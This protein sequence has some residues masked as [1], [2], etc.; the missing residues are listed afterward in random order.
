MCKSEEK[1]ETW[2]DRGG[3]LSKGRLGR[4][5]NGEGP[6]GLAFSRSE[7]SCL[8]RRV[9]WRAEESLGAGAWGKGLG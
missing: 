6:N 1:P 8:E 5:G 2:A 7:Y 4:I 3:L 9:N